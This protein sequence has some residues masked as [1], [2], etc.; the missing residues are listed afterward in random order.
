MILIFLWYLLTIPTDRIACTLWVKQPPTA[1]AL[2][3]ACG[4]NDLGKYRQAGGDPRLFNQW[5]SKSFPMSNYMS[6]VHLGG[7]IGA[8]GNQGLQ[9]TPQEIEAEIKRRG[10]K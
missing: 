9:F 2:I 1:E 7:T 6:D 4:F 3:A 5:Y 10:L 8:P